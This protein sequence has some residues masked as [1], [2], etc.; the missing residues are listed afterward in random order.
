MS[1]EVKH[2]VQFF[3]VAP[4]S[5]RPEVYHTMIDERD[6]DKVAASL[7][8]MAYAFQLFDIVHTMV[9]HD[10]K[11]V[12]LASEPI[13]QSK[14]FFP[15]AEIM[16]TKEFRFS[17]EKNAEQIAERLDQDSIEKVIVTRS[18]GLVPWDEQAEVVEV[19]GE[20]V[21]AEDIKKSIQKAEKTQ[22]I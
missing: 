13:N 3:I 22:Q 15:D 11:E 16:T 4:K 9:D 18:G 10:D 6:E 12:E 7:P 17:G 1:Y 19:K 2:V 8:K 5:G 21:G 20:I 14:T